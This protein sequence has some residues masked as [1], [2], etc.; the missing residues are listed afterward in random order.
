MFCPVN[1]PPVLF[2][3]KYVQ[4]V[5]EAAQV[6]YTQSEVCRILGVGL[7]TL[8]LWRIIS[9]AFAEALLANSTARDD[10]VEAAFF[11]R[12]V[13]YEYEGE[14][15]FCNADGD[16]TRT[17]TIVHVPADPTAALKWLQVHKPEVYA[18]AVGQTNVDLTVSVMNVRASLQ[19][20]LAGMAARIT[21][22]SSSDEGQE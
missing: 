2:D 12:A 1:L 16:V 13:G 19:G 21:S 18:Q 14:K 6:G 7:D 10:R 4:V 22:R 15:I 5:L 11:Q 3:R 17:R 9:P 20:K 8:N